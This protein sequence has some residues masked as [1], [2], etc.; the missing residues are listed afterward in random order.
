MMRFSHLLHQRLNP[1]VPEG[2]EEFLTH[3]HQVSAT[4]LKDFYELLV[5]SGSFPNELSNKSAAQCREQIE[6]VQN[7]FQIIFVSLIFLIKS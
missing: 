5:A 6:L 4:V 7:N 3:Y 1:T 2:S